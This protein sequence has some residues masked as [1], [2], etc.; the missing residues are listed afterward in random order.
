MVPLLSASAANRGWFAPTEDDQK[1]ERPKGEPGSKERPRERLQGVR[2]LFVK[3]AVAII[4]ANEF[5]R[6]MESEAVDE[7]ETNIGWATLAFELESARLSQNGAP[8][9]A[10][11]LAIEQARA[12]LDPPG[13]AGLSYL[14]TGLMDEGAGDLDSA[15]FQQRL[16]DRAIDFSFSASQDS[17]VGRLRLLSADRDEA[18]ALLGQALT[19]PRFDSEPLTRVRTQVIQS[20]QQDQVEPQRVAQRGCCFS[21]LSSA[22]RPPK[23]HWLAMSVRR[24]AMWSW[25]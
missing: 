24:L 25:Q 13:K 4:E 15:A 19:R 20:L 14:G 7:L 9:S 17:V 6:W 10:D 12:A 23:R 8:F 11:M 5:I 18:F 21:I 3:T 2:E 1:P 22:F 16:A